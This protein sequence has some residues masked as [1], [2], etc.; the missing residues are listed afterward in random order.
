MDDNFL[1]TKVALINL[2]H[3]ALF[4]QIYVERISLSLVINFPYH[5]QYSHFYQYH[6]LASNLL[7]L[8]I[9]NFLMVVDFNYLPC[10]K[11]SFNIFIT[12]ISRY[13]LFYLLIFRLSSFLGIKF[14][15]RTFV[16]FS[17]EKNH[18]IF[19]IS[20]LNSVWKKITSSLELASTQKLKCKFYTT[21]N[22]IL[23]NIIKFCV[24]KLLT[25]FMLILTKLEY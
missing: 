23:Y 22:V 9:Y 14:T 10:D 4:N 17:L 2:K 8:I 6:F 25:V 24:W 13:G 3:S 19:R 7:K 21:Y 16:E 15:A 20:L 12:L 5:S 18:F 1:A 11:H